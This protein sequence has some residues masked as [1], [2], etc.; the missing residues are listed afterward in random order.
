MSLEIRQFPCLSDNYGFL[1]RDPASGLVAAIDAPD[2]SRI[3][4]EV[5]AADWGRLDLVLLTHWH[6]DHTGGAAELKALWG[7]EIVG[8][9]EGLKWQQEPTEERQAHGLKVGP[10]FA[11]DGRHR[12]AVPRPQP[13]PLSI[14]APSPQ[15]WP[16]GGQA[17]EMAALGSGRHDRKRRGGHKTRRRQRLKVRPRHGLGRPW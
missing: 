16:V 12:V 7:A 11:A 4:L 10:R 5:Q 6:P 17:I 9:A 8:P 15:L 13:H 3:S 14:E 2:A 1:L